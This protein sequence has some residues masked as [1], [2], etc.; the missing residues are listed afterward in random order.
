MATPSSTGPA[1]GLGECGTARNLTE[2]LGVV[3]QYAD[4]KAAHEAGVAVPADLLEIANAAFPDELGEVAAL[5]AAASTPTIR[6][7]DRVDSVEGIEEYL[8]DINLAINAGKI[9][10]FDGM[11]KLYTEWSSESTEAGDDDPDERARGRAA[12]AWVLGSAMNDAHDV[13][14]SVLTSGALEAVIIPALSDTSPTVRAKAVLATSS[15]LRAATDFQHDIK[16]VVPTSTSSTSGTVLDTS[17]TSASILTRFTASNGVPPLLATLSD[18]SPR[19]ATRARHLLRVATNSGLPWLPT[20]ASV[21]PAA[22]DAL[23]AALRRAG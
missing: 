9:G 14:L 22:L 18:P 12:C 7:S 21:T 20:A 3:S 8:C 23:A 13:K 4:P 17:H 16:A 15:L 10:V 1:S 2:L 19:V 5:L 6:L 11:V